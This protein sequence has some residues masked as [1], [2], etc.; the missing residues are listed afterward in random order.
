M[1]GEDFTK[2]EYRLIFLRFHTFTISKNEYM[3]KLL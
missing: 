2:K 3:S 1:F